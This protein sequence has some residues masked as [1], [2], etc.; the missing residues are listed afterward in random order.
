MSIASVT[1]L[2]QDSGPE[3]VDASLTQPDAAGIVL[4]TIDA[5]AEVARFAGDGRRGISLRMGTFYGPTSPQSQEI[6]SYARRSIAALPGARDAYQSSIWVDDAARAV[7]TALENAPSGVYDVVDDEPLTRREF[8][9]AL[10]QASGR[11][12]LRRLPGL[13][14]NLM[15]GSQPGGILGRSQRV[16]NRQLREETGWAPSVPSARDGWPLLTVVA[17][18][19]E[20]RM[21]HAAGV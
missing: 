21:A 6:L 11:T 7:V 15:I 3:W 1:L 13:L 17:E 12:H 10:A 14:I 5:E 19:A 2:Y 18:A 8:V 16:S 20:T 9:E 4:S